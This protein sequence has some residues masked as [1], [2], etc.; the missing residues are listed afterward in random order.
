MP[1]GTSPAAGSGAGRRGAGGG[2]AAAKTLVID[3]SF[4]L[5]TAGPGRIYEPTGLTIG[6]AAYET[7]PSAS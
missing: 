1:R 5:K 6:K 4:D 7:P 3:T 2:T